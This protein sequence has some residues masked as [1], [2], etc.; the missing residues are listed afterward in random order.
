MMSIILFKRRNNTVGNKLLAMLMFFPVFTIA[1]NI[2]LFLLKWHNFIFLNSMN[3]AVIITFGPVFISYLRVLQGRNIKVDTR[4][5]LHFIPSIL[6][7]VSTLQY[8]IMTDSQR[9][10]ALNRILAGE[11]FYT[12]F[13]NLLLLFHVMVYLIIAHRE[14]RHYASQVLNFYSTLELVQLKW[15][16]S[17][18]NF[19]TILNSSTLLVFLLPI[20]VTGKGN[21]YVDLVAIPGIVCFLYG[22]MMYKG[23]SYNAI[24]DQASYKELLKHTGR[25]NNF[26]DLQLSLNEDGQNQET[27]KE[28]ITTCEHDEVKVSEI[29]ELGNRIKELV[30]Q[31]KIFTNRE[32]NLQKFSDELEAPAYLVSKIIT[33]E[34]NESFYDLINKRR[35]Q[36][37][38][39]LLLSETNFSIEG[40]AYE[41][42]FN[43][44]STFYRAFK[45]YIGQH[46]KEF[47]DKKKPEK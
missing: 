12:N 6:I 2:V 34:L 38:Q 9:I 45:K 8:F 24:Y 13:I 16:R 35:I 40:I 39:E 7:M 17:V 43:S 15:M 10:I 28:L 5:V 3:T 20:I 11:D 32:L 47:L 14:V 44:R 1:S 30:N 21:I 19:I 37:A 18:V 23:F 26:I 31:E 36:K 4:L 22:F 42:G 33:S 41:V 27:N 29:S 25:L 46:P